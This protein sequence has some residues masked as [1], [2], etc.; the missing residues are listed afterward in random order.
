MISEMSL[1]STTLVPC[2]RLEGC[3]GATDQQEFELNIF[4]GSTLVG[5]NTN[6]KQRCLVM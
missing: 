2:E 6:V 4:Y 3:G 1:V 5:R